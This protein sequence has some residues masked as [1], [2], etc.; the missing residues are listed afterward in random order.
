MPHMSQGEIEVFLVSV[1]KCNL[2]CL[3]PD[4]S[5][6]IVPVGFFYRDGG[7]YISGRVERWTERESGETP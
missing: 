3:E 4:G 1:G 7:F 5:P 2:A 6:Y